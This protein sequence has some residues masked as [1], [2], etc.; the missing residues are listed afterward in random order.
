[1]S[2]VLCI[3]FW[4]WLFDRRQSKGGWGG[5]VGSTTGQISYMLTKQRGGGAPKQR[6]GGAPKQRGG[7]VWWVVLQASF[8][9]VDNRGAGQ[10][11]KNVVH[12]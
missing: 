7:G 6:G 3:A 8:L 1:M 9:H 11:G 5:L 12:V 10:C 2:C 4:W